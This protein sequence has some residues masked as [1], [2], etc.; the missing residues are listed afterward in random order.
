[1]PIVEA[2]YIAVV[3]VVFSCILVQ[4]DMIFGWYGRLL[5]RLPEWIGSPLGLCS[6]CFGGQIAFW[7]FIT[8]EGYNPIKHI[9]FIS[10]T[11]FIIH[12]MLFVYERTEG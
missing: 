3:A 12:L 8:L 9:V 4:Q 11:I 2:V 7:Y 10:I 1:M 6:Y 5:D